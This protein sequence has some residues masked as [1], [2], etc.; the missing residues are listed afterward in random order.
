[1]DAADIKY[2]FV[3]NGGGA[4]KGF[5]VSEHVAWAQLQAHPM[6]NKQA[7]LTDDLRQALQY[8][9]QE[10]REEIDEFRLETLQVFFQQAMSLEKERR[11]WL[12][13]S[14][15]KI[16]AVVTMLHGPLFKWCVQTTGSPDNSLCWQ[17]Q[18]GFPFLGKLPV[19]MEEH[20]DKPWNL[21]MMSKEELLSHRATTN[22]M[23]VNSL[24]ETENSQAFGFQTSLRMH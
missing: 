19:L 13:D 4:V 11:K 10:T 5:S 18:H 14:P 9:C 2:S 20:T 1:M 24:I 23:V 12:A 17:L 8:E 15:K 22:K 21:K 16:R 6:A 7:Q 3:N